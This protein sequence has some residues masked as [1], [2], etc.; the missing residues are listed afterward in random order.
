MDDKLPTNVTTTWTRV[1]P[2]K[3]YTETLHLIRI[4]L[5]IKITI[6]FASTR[7]QVIRHFPKVPPSSGAT[8]QKIH[9][10]PHSTVHTGPRACTSSYIWGRPAL[11]LLLISLFYYQLFTFFIHSIK[12]F[13]F[14]KQE[15]FFILLSVESFRH[16]A[17][18]LWCFVMCVVKINNKILLI[19]CDYILKYR[20]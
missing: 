14:V 6:S 10:G 1:S 12:R 16:V 19:L 7:A 3:L 11:I 20:N 13:S 8:E 15:K 5:L 4:N 17:V 2:S 18:I 9:C